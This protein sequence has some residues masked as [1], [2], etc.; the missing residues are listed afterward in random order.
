MA[1]P[2]KTYSNETGTPELKT[3]EKTMKELSKN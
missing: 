3:D 1:N 2:S